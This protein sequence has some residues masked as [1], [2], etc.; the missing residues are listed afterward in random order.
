MWRKPSTAQSHDLNMYKYNYLY[1]CDASNW[2]IEVSFSHKR[3]HC[4][5]ENA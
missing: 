2:I 3:C 4:L 5:F 1:V